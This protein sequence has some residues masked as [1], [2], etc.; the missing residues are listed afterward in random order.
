MSLFRM[1]GFDPHPCNLA[2]YP[3]KARALCASAL[4]IHLLA[5]HVSGAEFHGRA[6]FASAR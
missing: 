2:R 4:R 6:Q 5:G 1:T 3:N